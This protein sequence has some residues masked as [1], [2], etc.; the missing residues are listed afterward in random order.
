MAVAELLDLSQKSGRNWWICKMPSYFQ[1]HIICRS[2]KAFG[3]ATQVSHFAVF[4]M[5]TVRL[6]EVTRDLPGLWQ[7][8]LIRDLIGWH[9]PGDTSPGRSV[10]VFPGK[11]NYGGKTHHEGGWPY[12][13]SQDPEWKEKASWAPVFISLLPGW[14]CVTNNLMLS[15]PWWVTSLLKPQPSINQTTEPKRH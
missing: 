9:L 8:I 10:R 6:E 12:S 11:F 4:K 13:T 7:L 14:S 1:T 15:G 3:E 2:L 5:T